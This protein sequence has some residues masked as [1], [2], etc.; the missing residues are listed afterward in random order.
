MTRSLSL[1]STTTTS[2]GATDTNR[3]A[4]IANVESEIEETKKAIKAVQILIAKVGQEI[5]KT[6]KKLLGG[7]LSPSIESILTKKFDGLMLEKKTLMD[8]KQTLMNEKQTL[9][10][11]TK[12]TILHPFEFSMADYE[13]FPDSGGGTAIFKREWLFNDIA[14][15]V[16]QKHC[17][18]FCTRAFTGGLQLV[19]V[20]RFS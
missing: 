5:K 13:N 1:L 11:K 18:K 12:S 15:M 3:K 17:G 20:R 14:D 6:E 7:N 16:L 19:Q 9:M 8:E 10:G 4:S 2:Q